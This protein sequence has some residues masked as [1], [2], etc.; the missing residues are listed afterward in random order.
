M[1]ITANS[2]PIPLVSV[3][4]P[5]YNAERYIEQAIESILKQNFSDFELI[6][7]NDGSVD[8]THEVVMQFHDPRIRYY[9]HLTNQGIVA[10]R[11]TLVQHARGKYIALLDADD[12]ALPERLERQVQ[13]LESR[14]ADICGTDH[15]TL[16]EASGRKK[17]SKQVHSNAD[18]HAMLCVSSPLCNPS[19]M[20]KATIFKAHPF[21]FGTDIVEDYALWQQLALKGYRFSNLKEYLIYYR[22]HPNQSSQSKVDQTS[23]IFL[24][25]RE[26]YLHGLGIDLCLTPRPLVWYDR[27]RLAPQFI[28]TINRKIE[29]ISF[30]ANYQLYARFQFRKNGIWTLLTRPERLILVAIT[31]LLARLTF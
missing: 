27:I 2:L 5:A 18:I 11:N 24:R 23:A 3:L 31:S 15:F 7:L 25:Q 22:I 12:I 19:V 20:A 29:G 30:R 8:R 14:H 6:V 17:K 1:I 13:H 4:M 26:C 9:Q 21:Q 28:F 10:V 16:D